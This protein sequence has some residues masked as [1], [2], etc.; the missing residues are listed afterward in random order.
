MGMPTKMAVTVETRRPGGL[1]SP[2]M[3]IML[4][5]APP[6]PRPVSSRSTRSRS[7][8]A[9]MAVSREKTPNQATAATSTGLRPTRSAAQPP[10]TAPNTRPT[11]AMLPARPTWPWLRCSAGARVGAAT[12]IAWMS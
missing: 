9:T 1:T 11:M 5:M 8:L 10:S 7:G 4:G 6:N 12:P 2:A 3:A